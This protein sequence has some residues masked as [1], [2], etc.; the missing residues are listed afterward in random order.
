MNLERGEQTKRKATLEKL[1]TLVGGRLPGIT[2]WRSQES[3][4]SKR[5]GRGKLPF[6]PNSRTFP[7]WK[8]PR[9]RRPS[10]R[11]PCRL[12]PNRSFVRPTPTSPMPR[13]RP[14]LLISPTTQKEWIPART[15]ARMRKSVRRFPSI[16]SHSSEMDVRSGTEPSYIQGFTWENRRRLGKKVSSTPTWRSWIDASLERGSSFTLGPS[17]AAMG[18]GSLGMEPGM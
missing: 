13:F 12:F 6:W 3:P 4:V 18:L 7:G 1:A 5:P 10:F 11:S 15:L 2:F 8:K 9:P 16:L 17:S 14:T